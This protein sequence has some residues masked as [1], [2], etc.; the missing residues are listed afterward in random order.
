MRALIALA[1]D[2]NAFGVF[3]LLTLVLGGGAAALTGRAIAATWRPW[4]HV[5]PLALL[6]GAAVRFLHF[7]L[8]GGMLFSLPH[9][10]AD[11][12]VCLA[13]GLIGFRLTRVA[14]MVSSYGWIN[15]RG[16]LYTWRRRETPSAG[17]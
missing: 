5:I 15:E 17:A 10:V 16:N 3:V 9:Y 1:Y 12:A 4:W 2:D 11:T 8:F 6:L 13:A 7:A 14:Q